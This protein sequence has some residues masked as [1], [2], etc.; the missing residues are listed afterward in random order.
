MIATKSSVMILGILEGYAQ[1]GK[2]E[3]ILSSVPIYPYA[4]DKSI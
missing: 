4:Y 3:G 2:I 1:F